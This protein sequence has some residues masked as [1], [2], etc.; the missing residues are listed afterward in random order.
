LAASSSRQNRVCPSSLSW[1]S[2]SAISRRPYCI[3]GRHNLRSTRV[4]SL[5]VPYNQSTPSPTGFRSFQDHR[6]VL[7]GRRC[8]GCVSHHPRGDEGDPVLRACSRYDEA[9]FVK[10]DNAVVMIEAVEHIVAIARRHDRK[11]FS[12]RLT[13]PRL[14]HL[15]SSAQP[16]KATRSTPSR[17]HLVSSIRIQRS[18]ASRR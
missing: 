18:D 6:S 8:D 17:R 16:F 1:A 4:P 10:Q 14:Q 2:A 15:Q 9:I 7:V 5:Q 13:T 3:S 12:I 11:I